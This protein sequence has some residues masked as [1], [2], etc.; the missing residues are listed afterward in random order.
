MPTI[1][2]RFSVNFGPANA[3]KAA[4]ITYQLHGVPDVVL[5]PA[6]NAGVAEF[7]AGSG[8]YYVNLADFDMAWSGSIVWT[9]SDPQTCAVDDFLAPNLL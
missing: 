2:R 3:G 5:V 8:C 6:T 1:T 4:L 7:P 9:L